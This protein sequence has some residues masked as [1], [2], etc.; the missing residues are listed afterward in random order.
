ME[1]LDPTAVDLSGARWKKSSRSGNTGG[2]C[3]EVAANLPGLIAL[4]DSKHPNNPP[5]VCTPE[6]WRSF[7]GVVKHHRPAF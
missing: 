1:S 2:N 7:I 6:A 4:R 3:V 5:L